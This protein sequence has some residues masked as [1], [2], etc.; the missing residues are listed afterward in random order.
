MDGCRRKPGNLPVHLAGRYFNHT[1]VAMLA[2]RCGRKVYPVHRIDRE[3]SGVVLLAFD[4]KSAGKL[5]ESTGSKEYLALV[6]GDF[7]DEV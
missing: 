2:D 4:G 3:T 5:S 6:H 7:P 1:L